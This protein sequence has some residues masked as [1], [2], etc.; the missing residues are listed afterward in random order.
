VS[1]VPIPV[2]E[3]HLA[4]FNRLLLG[5]IIR[6]GAGNMDAVVRARDSLTPERRAVFDRVCLASVNG[7]HITTDE[8]ASALGCDVS[9]IFRY[10]MEINIQFER[11]GAPICVMMEGIAVE[12]PDDSLKAEPAVLMP[13]PVAR[14]LVRLGIFAEPE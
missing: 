14:E 13:P 3:E 7:G 2:P 1:S 9:D 11:G 8:L 6:G 12:T 5:I 4:E 10:L